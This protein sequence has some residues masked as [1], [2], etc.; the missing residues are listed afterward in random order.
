MKL[1]HFLEKNEVREITIFNQLV[2]H[3]GTLS[4]TEMIDYLHISKASLEND[5]NSLAGRIESCAKEVEVSFDGKTITLYMSDAF[6]LQQ[7]Y[8]LYLKESVKVLIIHYLFEHQEFSIAQLTQELLISE[9]SLFRRIK[10]LNR[11][12][13]EF[14]LKIRNGHLQGEELQIR[15]FYLQFYNYVVDASLLIKPHTEADARH[16]IQFMERSLKFS[17]VPQSLHRLT[18]WVIISKSR[19]RY[20]KKSYKSLRSLIQPYAT[21][22]LY[23]DLQAMIL[24]YYSRYSVEVED[25]EAMLF[26]AF[27]LAFPIFTEPDFHEYRLLRNRRNPVASMD[28]YIAETIINYFNFKKLP[29]MLER[30]M[31]YHL[32][33][34][35]SRLYFFHGDIEVYDY[36]SILAKKTQLTEEHLLPFSKTLLS[37]SS[38]TLYPAASL[39]DSSLLKMELLKYISLLILISLNMSKSI[40]IGIDLKMDRLYRETLT[41]LLMLKLRPINGIHVELYQA[42]KEYDLIL[43]NS[44]QSQQSTYSDAHVYVLSEILSSFDLVN[45][46]QIIQTLNTGASTV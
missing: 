28:T 46:R 23:R 45:I 39:E 20:S 11:Y 35:H 33:S 16:M 42:D 30:D 2:L 37:T 21:D 27:V 44:E 5:L 22:P 12:L 24:R 4:Y 7:I 6:S 17:V 10:E 19:I 15:Y 31:Y 43:T 8:Q 34:I 18:L 40:A 13:Q 32:S 38:R 3:A 9:S 1:E 25:A 26:F 14:Q 29:Y 36:E 41:E